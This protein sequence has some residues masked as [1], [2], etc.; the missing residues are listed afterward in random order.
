MR[1][2]VLTVPTDDDVDDEIDR[3]CLSLTLNAILGNAFIFSFLLVGGG[4]GGCGARCRHCVAHVL[5]SNLLLLLNQA[6][7]C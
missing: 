6:K 4:G 7:W 1:W 2:M 3:V 5:A